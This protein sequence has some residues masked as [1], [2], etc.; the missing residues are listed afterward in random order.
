ME[1]EA[2]SQNPDK[3]AQAW[4]VTGAGRGEILETPLVEPDIDGGVSLVTIESLYSGI[5]RGTE[6]LVFHGRVPKT[7]HSRMRAPFQEGDFP[8]PVKYGY[9]NVGRVVDG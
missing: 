1:S 8:W 5:S 9:A 2:E 4:W 7:E 6:S 3:P